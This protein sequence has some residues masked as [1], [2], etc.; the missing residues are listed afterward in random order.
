MIIFVSDNQGVLLAVCEPVSGQHHDLFEIET[1]FE[2]LLTMLEQAEIVIDGLFLNADAGFD[3]EQLRA[4]CQRKGIIA[5]I[6][7]NPRDTTCWDRDECFDSE[8]YRRRTQIERAFAI[9]D[10]FKALLIR[11]E[12]SARNWFCLNLIAICV[13]LLKIIN[14][15]KLS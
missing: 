10:G 12:T 1:H 2:Q 8:L 15:S 6:A 11:Y 14:L 5:N 7:F 9:L 4:L 13:H 3:S